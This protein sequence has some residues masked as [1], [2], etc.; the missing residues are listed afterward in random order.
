MIPSKSIRHVGRERSFRYYKG[1]PKL[2]NIFFSFKTVTNIRYL[3]SIF[4][5]IYRENLNSSKQRTKMNELPFLILR[6]SKPLKTHLNPKVLLYRI[7]VS[8]SRDTFIIWTVTSD[9]TMYVQWRALDRDSAAPSG[10][11]RVH[12]VWI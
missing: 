3:T 5:F 8:M 6:G 11:T 10:A 1:F 2:I 4:I 12:I 7:D 9:N